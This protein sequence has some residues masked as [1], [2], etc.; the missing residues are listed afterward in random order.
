MSNWY[1]F[2]SLFLCLLGEFTSASVNRWCV[3][4]CRVA[5][6]FSKC[7]HNSLRSLPLAPSTNLSSPSSYSNGLRLYKC[8]VHS[9]VS[10]LLFYHLIHRVLRVIIIHTFTAWSKLQKKGTRF[11]QFSSVPSVVFIQIVFLLLYI[12]LFLIAP[13]SLL[14]FLRSFGCSANGTF[15]VYFLQVFLQFRS[16]ICYFNK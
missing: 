2:L 11:A 7:G 6:F 5:L 3:C 9:V 10:E 15:G 14:D 13:V 8:Q 12:T 1:I 16:F 4:S